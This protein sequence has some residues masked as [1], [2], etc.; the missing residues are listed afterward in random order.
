MSRQSDGVSWRWLLGSLLVVFGCSCSGGSSSPDARITI[1]ATT[2]VSG[3][4]DVEPNTVLGLSLASPAQTLT[5]ADLIVTDGSNR[6]P[7]TVARV[8]SSAQWNWTPAG[9]LPRN[10]TITVALA[11]Q[12]IVAVFTVR[13]TL[14]SVSVELPLEE[15]DTALS[16]R[17][18]RSALRT[19]N[20]RVFELLQGSFELV[21]RFCTMPRG[22]RAIGDGRFVG[23]EDEAGVHYIVRGDLT[24]NYDRVPTPSGRLLG[25][26][27]AAGDVVVLVQAFAGT[28]AEHGL[29]RLRH[30]GVAFELVGPLSLLG[31]GDRPSIEA[32]GTVS[33]A[34]SDNGLP[35]LAR[36][37]PGDLAGQ[38]YETGLDGA[39]QPM[40]FEVQYDASDDG[41]GVMAFLARSADQTRWVVR[42]ARFDPASGLQL[43]PQELRSR[44]IGLAPTTTL[45]VADVT[46]GDQGSA[47]VLMTLASTSMEGLRTIRSEVVRVEVDDSIGTPFEVAE[48]SYVPW[49][50]GQPG[51]PPPLVSFGQVRT[52]P[53]RAEVWG[54]TRLPSSSPMTL[55][56]SR[57]NG[58]HSTPVYSFASNRN[59]GDWAFTFDDSGR[60][61]YA[62]VEWELLGPLIGT[63]IVVLE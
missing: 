16:W 25:D 36:F 43:L 32:D 14:V 28:P 17:N 35:R 50:Q 2:P 22:A 30:D 56:L 61:F 15:I 54:M 21:E 18:G 62:V 6:L 45:Q 33:I 12:G 59:Y 31:V 57:P 46:V 40:A 60:G 42:A 37:A 47:A 53:G 5:A 27:N 26:V 19:R 23:E 63:R 3:A 34:W 8:G 10:T 11:G 55:K 7:G 38:R 39:I 9:E 29:W 44:L 1:V 24:G 13:D 4:T 49:P 51:G 41:R 52:S 48:T 58:T 20:G